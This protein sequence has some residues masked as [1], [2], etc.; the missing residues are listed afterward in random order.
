MSE[1]LPSECIKCTLSLLSAVLQ[2]L[3]ICRIQ[4]YWSHDTWKILQLYSTQTAI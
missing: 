3:T 4:Y 2:P 1:S